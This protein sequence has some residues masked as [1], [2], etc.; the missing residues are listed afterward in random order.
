LHDDAFSRFARL[1]TLYERTTSHNI[2]PRYAGAEFA[3]RGKQE[4]PK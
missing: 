2:I 4:I 1:L 3:S